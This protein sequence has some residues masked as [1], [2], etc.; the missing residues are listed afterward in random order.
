MYLFNIYGTYIYLLMSLFKCLYNI[1]RIL[2]VRHSSSKNIRGPQSQSMVK[3]N[4]NLKKGVFVIKLNSD[5]K[6]FVGAPMRLEKENIVRPQRAKVKPKDE[7]VYFS[8]L[9]LCETL[10]H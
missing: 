1:L 9:S 10:M 6:A 2:F 8:S 3:T 4:Y 7:A 5:I